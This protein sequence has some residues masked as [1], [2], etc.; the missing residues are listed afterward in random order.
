MELHFTT[1]YTEIAAKINHIDPVKYGQTRNYINGAVTYLSPYIARGVI[2]TK[3]VLEI[4]LA[5]GYKIPQIESF[6]KELCWRD[7][8]QR[9]AQTKNVNHEIK[10]PQAVVSNYAISTNIINATTG[11]EGIDTAI[12]QLYLN[13]YMHNHCRMYTAALVCNIAK[14]H[15]LLPAQWMYYHL[16]DGDWASNACSWQWVAGANSSKKYY[17][18]QENINRYTNTNQL[19]TYL[20][21][22]YEVLEGMERPDLL[23]ETQKPIFKTTLPESNHTQI[24]N[25]LPTFIYNYYNLDPLWHKEEPGN[26]ILLIEPHFFQQYPI[27]EKCTQFMLSLSNNIPD[28]QLYVGSFKSLVETYSIKDRYYKEHPLNIGYSGKMENRDWISNEVTGYFPSFF[29]YWKKIEKQLKD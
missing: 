16:L 27:S 12:Q 10:Q 24:D 1:D 23:S 5:K 29:S 20:D 26:R 8:F 3:Q 17:A 2:S 25:H 22:P 18:N 19:N 11:I 14:S 4:I 9:V 21:K 13:G 7:Y 28:I 6:V 15:W